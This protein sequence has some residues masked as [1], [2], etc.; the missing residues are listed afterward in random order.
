M[1]V[2]DLRYEVTTDRSVPETVARVTE[3]LGR[4]RFSVLWE[5]DVN[6][7]LEE[8]GLTLGL[9]YRILEVCS[10]P[11]AK[12]ALETNP[13]VGYFLPC[14]VVVYAEGGRTHIGLPRP[15]ALIEMVGD[16]RLQ[17]LAAEVEAT[18]IAAVDEASAAS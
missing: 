8:K 17:G 16:P 2:A 9:P 15:Q 4:R 13:A 3:A 7:K 6:A 10:A 1:T 14:K 5:L 18:L 11:R 12:E